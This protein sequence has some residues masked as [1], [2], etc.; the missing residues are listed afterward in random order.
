MGKREPLLTGHNGNFGGND[1]K[2]PKLVVV[3]IIQFSIC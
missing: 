1:E 2:V 3:M